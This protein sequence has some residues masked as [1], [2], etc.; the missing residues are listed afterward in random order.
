M[1][2]GGGGE[3]QPVYTQ[4][5]LGVVVEDGRQ[6]EARLRRVVRPEGSIYTY[7]GQ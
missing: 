2:A 5:W 3:V 6:A 1:W 7:F 4:A